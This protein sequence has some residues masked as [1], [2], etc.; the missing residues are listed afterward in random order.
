MSNHKSKNNKLKPLAKIVKDVKIYNHCYSFGAIILG[1]DCDLLAIESLIGSSND[2]IIVK[3]ESTHHYKIHVKKY[4]IGIELLISIYKRYERTC[5][6]GNKIFIKVVDFTDED[7]WKQSYLQNLNLKAYGDCHILVGLTYP[8]ENREK[9][10]YCDRN[11]AK[12]ILCSWTQSISIFF[13]L[14]REIINYI[15]LLMCNNSI[16][17]NMDKINAYTDDNDIPIIRIYESTA[18]DDIEKLFM[19]ICKVSSFE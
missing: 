10:S 6:S 14:P 2:N 18:Y 9:F 1:R 4:K 5:Y 3:K 7:Y 19:K 17:V 12:I 13:E 11:R 15:L 16:L 8:R